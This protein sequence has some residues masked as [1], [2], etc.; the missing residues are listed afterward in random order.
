MID[1]EKAFQVA[2]VGL[3]GVFAGLIF[4]NLSVNLFAGIFRLVERIDVKKDPS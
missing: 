2:F 3:S 1:L 4:L